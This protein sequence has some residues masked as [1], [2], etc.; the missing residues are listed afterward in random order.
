MTKVGDLGT[1][2]NKIIK[3]SEYLIERDCILLVF[4]VRLSLEYR[5]FAK[6]WRSKKK[7]KKKKKT[8]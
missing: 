5:S 7:K 1:N 2:L 8:T 4:I 3:I 6:K